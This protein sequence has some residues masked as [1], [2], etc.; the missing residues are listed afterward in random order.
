[1]RSRSWI[2]LSLVQM[3][4]ISSGRQALEGACGTR[5]TTD[6]GGRPPVPRDQLP[7]EVIGC[8]RSTDSQRNL[9]SFRRGVPAGLSGMTTDHLRPVLDHVEDTHL[10]FLM[11]EQLAQARV[12]PTIHA[13]TRK[14]R[15]I[16]LQKPRGGVRG[17][18]VSEGWR[19][20]RWRNNSRW[21]GDCTPPTCDVHEGC[22]SIDGVER[23]IPSRGRPCWRL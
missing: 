16:A 2:A 23:T 12:P 4:E 3:E 9:R 13:T 22:M 1:M 18:V 15:M 14:E 21:D 19:H 17:I 20:E 11:G 10:F 5:E 7:P 8:W 6:S